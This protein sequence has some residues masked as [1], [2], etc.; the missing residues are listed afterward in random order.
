M[1]R[2]ASIFSFALAMIVSTTMMAQSPVGIWKTIDDESGEPKSHVEIYEKDGKFYGK[3]VKLLEKATTDVCGPCPGERAGKSLIDMD[4]LWDLEPYKDYWSYG[5]IID[6][7]KGKIYKASVWLEDE[8]TLK[9]RGY[10]GISALGRN[11]N[12]YRVTE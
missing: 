3:V 6:P 9:V 4:I 7:G 2:I 12:W 5:Q 8:N 11:Q 10:I 1:K